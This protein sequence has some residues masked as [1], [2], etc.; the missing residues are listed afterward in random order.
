[1]QHKRR[2]FLIGVAG[3]ASALAA[4]RLAFAQAGAPVSET[5][6]QA[7]ALGYKTDATK[8]DKVRFPKYAAGQ[9]CRARPRNISPITA[10][11]MVPVK[12]VSRT[13]SKLGSL[14]EMISQDRAEARK[15]WNSS[16][17]LEHSPHSNLVCR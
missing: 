15:R 8:A 11:R 6:A 3:T 12:A 16:Q 5:G 2:T 13:P 14:R 9:T 10:N 17:R 4:L 7:Q 1:M